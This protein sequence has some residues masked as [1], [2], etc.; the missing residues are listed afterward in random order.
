M[1]QVCNTNQIHWS[2]SMAL[3]LAINKS[4]CSLLEIKLEM[5]ILDITITVR[6]TKD[7]KQIKS[8]K[9][10]IGCWL[11][12][13]VFDIRSIFL[14]RYNKQNETTQWNNQKRTIWS[15]HLALIKRCA[16]SWSLIFWGVKQSKAS[17]NLIANWCLHCHFFFWKTIKKFCAFPISTKKNTSNASLLDCTV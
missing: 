1:K 16:N 7:W 15:P 3:F 9:K 11:F 2:V 14:L 12:G 10:Q 13:K 4:I 6:W 17:P 5:D 8:P